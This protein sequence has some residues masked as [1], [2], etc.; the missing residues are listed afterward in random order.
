[1]EPGRRGAQRLV[2]ASGEVVQL[3][4]IDG[5]EVGEGD[6]LILET[7]GGGAWGAPTE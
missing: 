5:A 3:A 2:R 4:P 6:R 1:G 7:P